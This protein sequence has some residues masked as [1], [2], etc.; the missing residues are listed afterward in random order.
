M[1]VPTCTGKPPECL[2]QLLSRLHNSR[3][4]RRQI[5]EVLL[6][7]SAVTGS[8]PPSCRVCF[9]YRILVF[10][11]PIWTGTT[12]SPAETLAALS[13]SQLCSATAGMSG[14]FS[15]IWPI[16]KTTK[17]SSMNLL[18]S[19]TGEQRSSHSV[20]K[21][22]ELIHWEDIRKWSFWNPS[23]SSRKLFQQTEPPHQISFLH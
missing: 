6:S 19:V 8:K 1:F 2:Q 18:P 5:L 7:F 20:D 21:T 3:A 9:V 23:A 15:R 16:I 12:P 13:R 22:G 17:G 10:V 14:V 11:S 4:A